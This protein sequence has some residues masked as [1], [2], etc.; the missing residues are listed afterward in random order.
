MHV[1]IAEEHALMRAGIR[2]LIAE[3]HGAEVVAEARD[4][5]EALR[6]IAEKRPDVALVDLAIPGLGG[7]DVAARARKET[8]ST[9]VLIVSMHVADEHVRGALLAGAAGYLHKDAD[10]KELEMALRTVARGE[11]WLSPQMSRP[12]VAAYIK[13]SCTAVDE[14]FEVLTPR[15]REVLQ[16]I[17]EGLLSKEIAAQLG[18]SLKTVDT[19]RTELMRRLGIRGIAGLVRYAVRVGLVRLDP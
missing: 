14:P 9:R 3:V 15:Q 18:V 10:R 17:A 4:G 5:H 13:G 11:Q 6:L 12:I 1:L 7:L 19:H 8:P 16:L 2:L